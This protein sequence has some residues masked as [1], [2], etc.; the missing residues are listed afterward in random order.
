MSFDFM[1]KEIASFEETKN[2]KYQY[3]EITTVYQYVR[4]KKAFLANEENELYEPVLNKN[5]FQI[6]YVPSRK[7]QEELKI[8]E[9]TKNIDTTYHNGYLLDAKFNDFELFNDE[10]KKVILKA[11]E[12]VKKFEKK[13]FVKGLYLHGQNRTGKTFLLSA[14]VN[15]LALKDVKIVF[16]YVPDLI[17]DIHS[18]IDE[19]LL[20]EK[21]R[22]L[23]NCEL[24]VLDDLGSAFMNRW[25]R[26]QVFGP[27]IQYRLS[28][29]LPLLVS[30]NL[31]I[32]QLA[33]FMIDPNIKNDKFAAVRITTRIRELTTSVE[34][35]E[36]RY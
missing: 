26:D 1:I 30:S 32:I 35:T 36:K 3:H 17:R 16:V 6:G 5:P 7:H 9:K 11:K 22:Q 15:E 28:V 29:G 8:K 19:G 2:L 10:R 23:K 24:L 33:D 34:F 25:F 4:L 21:V 20:E 31:D 13:T 18:S 27:I 14:I 12:F